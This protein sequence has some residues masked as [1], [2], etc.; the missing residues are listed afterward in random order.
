[1]LPGFTPAL[2]SAAAA[3]VVS[4]APVVQTT[5]TGFDATTVTTHPIV[6]P[7]G[8]VAGDLIFIVLGLAAAG[9]VLSP[10]AGFTLLD[11]TSSFGAFY[12]VAV[13]GEGGTTVN[14][15]SASAQ[16]AQW[17]AYRISGYGGSISRG[18]IVT[19]STANPNP[20]AVTP[21][22]GASA[23]TLFIAADTIFSSKTISTAPANYS[24]LLT[25]TSSG[26]ATGTAQR[27]LTA[28]SEDPGTFTNSSTASIAAQT[29]AIKGT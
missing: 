17:T 1:M 18:T 5:N 23:A 4:A 26:A 8:I 12:K 27:A 24:N 15:T 25:A 20:P 19:G 11:G 2:F 9:I 28:A 14:A 10:P 16:R 22:W 6:L 3:A 21:S 29:Y 7:S 13:G